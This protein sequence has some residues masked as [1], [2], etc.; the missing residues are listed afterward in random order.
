MAEFSKLKILS[1]EFKYE[2]NE[3]L[4]VNFSN[5]VK[6]RN[7]DGSYHLQKANDRRKIDMV[8]A[9]LNAL[10]IA[11]PKYFEPEQIP[12]VIRIGS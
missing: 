2:E 12:S 4:E 10:F 8:A 9:L 6:V 11:Y 7:V 1:R 5:C 3:F